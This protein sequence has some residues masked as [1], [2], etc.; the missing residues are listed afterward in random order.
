MTKRCGYVAV[1]GRPNVGKSTLV[2]EIF[3]KKCAITSKR[4]QTTRYAATFVY[5]DRERE[6]QFLLVDTPGLLLSDYDKHFTQRMYQEAMSAISHLDIRWWLL[7]APKLSERDKALAQ[8]MQPQADKTI[9][10]WNKSDTV[11]SKTQ[12]LPAIAELQ[13]MGFHK[14]VPCCAHKRETLE[15]L[16]SESV[17]FLPENDYF[18]PV[19]QTH[20]CSRSFMIEEI[21]REKIMRYIGQE[22]PYFCYPVC[23]SFIERSPELVVCSV[24]IDIP[25][26]RYRPILLGA[27]GQ[28]IKKIGQAARRSLE[29][30]L[31]KKVYLKL[32]IKCD[33]SQNM[34]ILE[35]KRSTSLGWDS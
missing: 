22:V 35:Q 11:K 17:P 27:G 24:R 9:I 10:V 4:A 5:T 29:G 28:Q 26:E 1:V 31:K 12:L 15:P 34:G 23:E 32:W 7:E 6:A 19:E 18:Y 2:N 14:Q 25:S 33:T 20:T 16:L 21:I 3:G 30:L 8:I 13:A